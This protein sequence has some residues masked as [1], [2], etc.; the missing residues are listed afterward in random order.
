MDSEENRKTNS[1]QPKTAAPDASSLKPE[2]EKQILQDKSSEREAT[3][4]RRALLQ[5]SVPAIVAITLPQDAHAQGSP[6]TDVPHTDSPHA[7]H[8]DHSDVHTDAPHTD[9]PHTD[10][11]DGP[12]VDAP[13]TD[14]H[15]DAHADSGSHVDV[16]HVDA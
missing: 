9:A 7:D 15:T 1:D 4:L 2:D 12:H 8:G 6:H 3:F 5:W 16:P 14:A 13:H 10:H 11:G